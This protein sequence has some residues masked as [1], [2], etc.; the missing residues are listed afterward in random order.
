MD[1]GAGA[2]TTNYIYYCVYLS[3][4]ISGKQPVGL[5]RLGWALFLLVGQR[6]PTFCI[7]ATAGVINSTSLQ[8]DQKIQI[9]EVHMGSRR[10]KAIQISTKCF[11]IL[12]IRFIPKIIKQGLNFTKF[13]QKVNLG[14]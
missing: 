11:I 6:R 5:V 4:S 2:F 9:I 3:L 7:S 1:T 8:L 10:K 14:P 13:F 12:F